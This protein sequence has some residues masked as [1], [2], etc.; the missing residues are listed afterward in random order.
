M[1]FRAGAVIVC[2]GKGKRLGKIDKTL[3]KL[4]GDPLF[5]HTFQAF[6][7][8]KDIKQIVLVLRRQYVPIAKK[9]IKDKRV[10]FVEGGK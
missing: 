8:I 5:Y 1:T 3:L 4:E 2:A 9:L 6:R 7:K 10:I